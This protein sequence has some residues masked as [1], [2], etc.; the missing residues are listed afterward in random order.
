MKGFT[1][2]NI[3]TAWSIP[4][5]DGDIAVSFGWCSDYPGPD[6]A[7]E[8]A[9]ALSWSHMSS[10]RWLRKLEAASRLVGRKRLEALGR[11][12]IEIMKKVA[13]IAP[14]RTFNNRYFFS[15]RVD[16]QSLVY[17]AVY[18]DW[19]IPALALK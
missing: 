8:I 18:A 4:G 15:N 9:A 12:D 5:N 6:P 1:G 13:P 16:P 19:S 7:A 14:E 10:P 2:G 11:L 3:Y 17:Q